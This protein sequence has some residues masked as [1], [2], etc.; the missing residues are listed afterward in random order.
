MNKNNSV[1][2]FPGC[3]GQTANKDCIGANPLKGVDLAQMKNFGEE[4]TRI[5][6]GPK[7]TAYL[8][9]ESCPPGCCDGLAE[10]GMPGDDD[11][12]A[13][14]LPEDENAPGIV[15]M[16]AEGEFY[17][18]STLKDAIAV[19]EIVGGKDN[20][21]VEIAFDPDAGTLLIRPVMEVAD[22]GWIAVWPSDDVPGPEFVPARDCPSDFRTCPVG[23]CEFAADCAADCEEEN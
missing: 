23:D 14:I 5:I 8:V 10:H 4:L 21:E 19:A 7:A 17:K 3:N 13:V 1:G 16:T 2:P 18:I 12:E 22:N 6:F 9:A 15:R 11:Y 20:T